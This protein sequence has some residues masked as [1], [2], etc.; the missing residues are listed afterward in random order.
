[1]KKFLT[2]AFTLIEMMFLVILVGVISLYS[3]N[4]AR[5]HTANQTASDTAGLMMQWLQASQNYYSQNSYWPQSTN[6]DG[7]WSVLNNGGFLSATAKCSKIIQNSSNTSSQCGLFGIFTIGYAQGNDQ[8]GQPFNYQ[9]SQYISVSTPVGDPA[10]GQQIAAKLPNGQYVNGQ[11]I[12]YANIPGN[13]LSSNVYKVLLEGHVSPPQSKGTSVDTYQQCDNNDEYYQMYGSIANNGT[14]PVCWPLILFA[15][16]GS[17]LDIIFANGI[18]AVSS[19]PTN[20]GVSCAYYGAYQYAPDDVSDPFAGNTAQC[21]A[22]IPGATRAQCNFPALSG[23]GSPTQYKFSFTPPSGCTVGALGTGTLSL[24]PSGQ[25]YMMSP[26]AIGISG[27][28]FLNIINKTTGP[29]AANVNVQIMAPSSCFWLGGSRGGVN[30][31][32]GFSPFTV[33]YAPYQNLLSG[34]TIVTLQPGSSLA[35]NLEAL[36]IPWWGATNA[37]N[38]LTGLTMYTTW[39]SNPTQNPSNALCSATV[40]LTWADPVTSVCYQS[41]TKYNLG[42]AAVWPSSSGSSASL[43]AYCQVQLIQ[44]QPP[45]EVKCP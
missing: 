11:V 29:H 26:P 38:G 31:Q 4:L 9:S 28:A 12:G 30:T 25:P 35:D 44:T 40:T 32:T 7:G 18:P 33:D 10:L 39:D 3:V 8:N 2:H 37:G 5:Q 22:C 36:S 17:E 34:K 41:Q 13:D 6:G 15:Q 1:M 16:G 23:L 20:T 42:S 14:Q 19:K 43:A 27:A 21:Q 24:Q 45:T